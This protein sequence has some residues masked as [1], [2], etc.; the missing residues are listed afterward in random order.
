MSL[1]Q[2]QQHALLQRALP[3]NALFLRKNEISL[4][5]TALSSITESPTETASLILKDELLPTTPNEFERISINWEY[6][7]LLPTSEGREGDTVI[8]RWNDFEQ[9]YRGKPLEDFDRGL[10][11]GQIQRNSSTMRSFFGFQG[12][13]Y[14]LEIKSIAVFKEQPTEEQR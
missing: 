11:V 5:L 14:A 8:I 9:T 13:D 1:R 4:N 12:G 3:L 6:G 7:F 10:D 2:L